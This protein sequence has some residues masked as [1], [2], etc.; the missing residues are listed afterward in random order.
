MTNNSKDQLT[1][2]VKGDLKGVKKPNPTIIV[3]P[4]VRNVVWRK[5]VD[6]FKKQGLKDDEILGKILDYDGFVEVGLI[7][8]DNIKNK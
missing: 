2:I 1:A 5:L 8:E 7:T 3:G 6:K 4:R